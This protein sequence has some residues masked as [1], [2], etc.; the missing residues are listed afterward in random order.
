MK[1]SFLLLFVIGLFSMSALAQKTNIDGAWKFVS[2]N[3]QSDDLTFQDFSACY[4]CQLDDS[5]TLLVRDGDLVANLNGQDFTFQLEYEQG[6]LV[7][8]YQ[9]EVVYYSGET[10]VVESLAIYTYY[11][12]KKTLTLSQEENGVVNTYTFQRTKE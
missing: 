2:Y 9:Q 5:K 11:R 6:E 3:N 8:K 12:K 10:D 7:L 1:R 4:W